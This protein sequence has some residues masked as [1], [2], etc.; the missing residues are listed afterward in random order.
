MFFT[1]SILRSRPV[2]LHRET[3]NG[4]GDGSMLSQGKARIIGDSRSFQEKHTADTC[5]FLYIKI[6]IVLSRT[7]RA[8][9]VYAKF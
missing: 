2:V 4:G 1:E 5:Y 9:I 8:E 6:L 3:F 7:V